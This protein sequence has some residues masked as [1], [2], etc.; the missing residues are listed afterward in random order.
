MALDLG[1]AGK[2]AVITGGSAGIGR[3]TAERLAAEGA[4]VAICARDPV[5]IE[6]AADEIRRATGATVIAFTA[7]V[8]DPA[9]ITRFFA[10]VRAQLGPVAIL[11]NNAGTAAAAHFSALDDATWEA[12][13]NLKLLGAIRCSREALPDMQARRWGRIVNLTAIA[14]KAPGPGSMPSS[15]SR[16]AGIALTKALSKDVAGDGVT[17]NTVCIGFVRS[18]QI[19]RQTAALYPT[20]DLEAAYAE[21]GKTVPVG[22]IAY[23]SEAAD[24]IAFLV[25]ERA[26]YITGTAINFDGGLSAV[27]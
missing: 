20:L 18:A 14:G 26:G 7:D 15:V 4:L 23:A 17:V 2:V 24:L 5:A 8:R 13:L 21:R 6:H 10:H 19:D 25:S 12:D 11:V 16:A 1:I 9:A 22:R 27:V 3:A